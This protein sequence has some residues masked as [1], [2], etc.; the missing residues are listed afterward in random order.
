VPCVFVPYAYF[1]KSAGRLL[2]FFFSADTLRLLV[3]C[4]ERKELLFPF[5]FP[6]PL[7]NFLNTPRLCTNS[8]TFSRFRTPCDSLPGRTQSVRSG[9]ISLTPPP[10]PHSYKVPVPRPSTIP[11]PQLARTLVPSPCCARLSRP[12]H[13]RAMVLFEPPPRFFCW[14]FLSEIPQPLR[15]FPIQALRGQTSS[16]FFPPTTY[17]GT[18][19]LC[20]L[21][22]KSR[23][24]LPC[25]SYCPRFR[26]HFI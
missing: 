19:P 20:F 22:R 6:L 7:L 3:V 4:L 16:F 5:R 18:G 23:A 14:T 11:S 17:S 9:P 12:K 25:V 1:Y 15:G 10:P 2:P 8:P 21:A 26:P 24:N 13:P